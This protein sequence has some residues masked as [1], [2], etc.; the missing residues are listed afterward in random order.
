MHSSELLPV[1]LPVTQQPP[2]LSFLSPSVTLYI[3]DPEMLRPRGPDWPP[4]QNVGIGLVTTGLG[5]CLGTLCPRPQSFGIGLK[6]SALSQR[7]SVTI[8]M[9]SILQSV[10]KY[11]FTAFLPTNQHLG[12]YFTAVVHR[13]AH[14]TAWS[15]HD[16][17]RES[18]RL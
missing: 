14:D 7:N 1:I 11:S 4:G 15:L 12:G 10:S 13:K 16:R 5:L 2:P 9:K 3:S 6:F 8:A 17:I 18:G